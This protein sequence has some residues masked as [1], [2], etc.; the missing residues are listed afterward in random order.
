[1][2][3]SPTARPNPSAKMRKTLIVNFG[4]EGAGVWAGYRPSGATLAAVTEA[5]RRVLSN[6]NPRPWAEEPLAVLPRL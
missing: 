3:D 4:R 1:M 2:T 6:R 5:Q